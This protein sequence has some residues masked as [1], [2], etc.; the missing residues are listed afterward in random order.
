M[1]AALTEIA[2]KRKNDGED[3]GIWMFQATLCFWK[4]F[5]AGKNDFHIQ[6]F[7]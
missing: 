3:F 2:H 7:L 5:F 1:W 6:A 4:V